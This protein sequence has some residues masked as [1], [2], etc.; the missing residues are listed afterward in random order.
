MATANSVFGK[1]MQFKRLAETLQSLL[2]AGARG[3]VHSAIYLS[4]ETGQ[5]R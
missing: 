1:S 5:A 2:G 4:D 3:V